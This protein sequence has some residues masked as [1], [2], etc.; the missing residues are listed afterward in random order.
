MRDFKILYLISV[1][2]TIIQALIYEINNKF[3]HY[4]VLFMFMFSISA[5]CDIVPIPHVNLSFYNGTLLK[6][7]L[8]R[9][10]PVIL[11]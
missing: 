11:K 10:T 7:A 4:Y 5:R 6:L 1:K 8:L 2:T 3:Q 9:N